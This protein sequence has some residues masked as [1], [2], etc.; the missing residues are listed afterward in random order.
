M[1]ART[2]AEYIFCYISY[3]A[4]SLQYIFERFSIDKKI[5]RLCVSAVFV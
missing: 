2:R 3:I 5:Q 4:T 1:Y